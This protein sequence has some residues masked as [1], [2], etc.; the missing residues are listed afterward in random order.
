M[1]G[2][3][4]AVQKGSMSSQQGDDTKGWKHTV[5]TLKTPNQSSKFSDCCVHAILIL[6]SFPMTFPDIIMTSFEID[7]EASIPPLRP[8]HPA[9][10]SPASSLSSSYLF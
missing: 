5:S 7:T 1:P 6:R 3:K 8:L 2:T 10:S 4:L 9:S